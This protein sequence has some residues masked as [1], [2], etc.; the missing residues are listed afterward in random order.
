MGKIAE[1]K[2]L[3]TVSGAARL[4]KVPL[5]SLRDAISRGV[6]RVVRLGDGSIVVRLDDVREW[7]ARPRSPGR[8]R[9]DA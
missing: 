9:R 4:V 2:Q 6:V 7:A 5:S 3:A 8:P 1:N